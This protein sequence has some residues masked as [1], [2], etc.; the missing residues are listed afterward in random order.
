MDTDDSGVI[1]V[2]NLKDFLGDELSD[3]YLEG[4]LTEAHDDLD[5]HQIPAITY[6]EFLGLWNVQ[7]DTDWQSAQRSVK[8]HR[9]MKDTSQ[10]EHTLSSTLSTVSSTI[11]DDTMNDADDEV[12]N[13]MTGT[14]GAVTETPLKTGCVVFE[15]E[16][17]RS[18]V[19]STATPILYGDV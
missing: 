5:N 18:E 9:R 7:A 6:E 19:K 17:R 15:D 11:S 12:H 13:G 3:T 4:I 8:A 1:T 16:R 14:V 10:L 2:Q